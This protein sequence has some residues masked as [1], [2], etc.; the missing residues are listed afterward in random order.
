M[1]TDSESETS[2]KADA[3]LRWRQFKGR[4]FVWLLVLSTLFGILALAALFVVIGNDALGVTD[5]LTSVTVPLIGVSIPTPFSAWLLLYFGTLVAPISLYT[6]YIRRDLARKEVNAKSFVSV[7]GFLAL[8]FVVFAVGN[9]VRP[10]DLAIYLVFAA[11]SLGAVLAYRHRYGSNHYTGPAMPL[12]IIFGVVLARAL[13]APVNGAVAIL[14]DWIMFLVIATVPVAAALG[15]VA[16]KRYSRRA[17]LVSAALVFAGAGAAVGATLP[18]GMDPALWVVLASVFVAPVA[19]V[20]VETFR[21]RPSGRVGLLGPAV[22]IGGIAAG[23]VIEQSL[24]IRGLDAWLTPTLLL[25]SWSSFRPEQAGIYPQLIGSIMIVGT[26]ALLAFPVGVG[27]AI[28][29]EEYAP[30][31]GWR[32]RFATVLDINI[33][34]LAGVPS[35]VYG[36]LGLA[37][38]Q[39]VFGFAP[40]LPSAFG[41]APNLVIAAAV[42]L[43]FLILPIVIVSSQEALRAVPDE[44]RQGSYGLGASRW[45]TIRNVVLPEAVPGILTGTILALGR[46]IGETAPLVMIGVAATSFSEPEGLFSG[47]TALPLQI[48]ASAANAIPEYRT[49]VVAAASIVLLAVMLVMNA[50]AIVI[51]NRYENN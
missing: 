20:F 34:N 10:H 5:V 42:T 32:G 48:F 7:F 11:V 49:G 29:L 13:Y 3:S 51:R 31:T 46:A 25:D 47:A 35:V 38:F 22:L 17:G 45:Q 21:N 18:Q 41:L 27:A 37:L 12:S 6:L 2:F 16:S 9:A 26:M 36:L 1:A 40:G 23:A 15:Y 30:S 4:L 8:A 14:A 43:G 19:F 33:S 39:N 28:Y 50:T 24:G 44:L